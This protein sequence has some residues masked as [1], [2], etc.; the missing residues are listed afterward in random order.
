[1][2]NPL[3]MRR[4]II[5]LFIVG[6]VLQASSQIKNK[7]V[8]YSLAWMQGEIILETGDTI[9][10]PLRYNPLVTEG[11]LQ[12]LDH[13]NV[14]TLSVKD[15]KAFL[16]YDE[17]KQKTRRFYT[18]SLKID[19]THTREIFLEYVYGNTNVSIL[20]HKAM[21][22]PYD[23]MNYIQFVQKKSIV[24][25]KYLLNVHTGQLLPLSK[26][27]ALNLIGRKKPEVLSYIRTNKIK[28]KKVSDYVS[29]FEFDSSL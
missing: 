9:I 5:I 13:E 8:N 2:P 20:N 17:E 7:K 12:I 25:K 23:Y 19:Q 11:L 26:E 18:L 3:P 28:F 16:F 6:S 22:L 4:L 21:G 14:L 24:N 27:N 15:V 29:V 10:R 1:M